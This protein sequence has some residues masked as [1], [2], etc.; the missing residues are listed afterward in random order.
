MDSTKKVT[1]RD[2]YEFLKN[3]LLNAADN[4]LIDGDEAN[5]YI[6]FCDHEIELIDKKNSKAKERIANKTDSLTDAVRD[7][8]T[9]EFVSIPDI[10]TRIEGDEVT[11]AK[12]AYRLNAL[13]KDGFAEKQAITIPG[14]DGAKARTVQGYRLAADN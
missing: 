12:V 14:V 7:A 13:V 8:L 11:V 5:D 2:R 6:D 3:L 9:D 4:Q 10:T 1:K